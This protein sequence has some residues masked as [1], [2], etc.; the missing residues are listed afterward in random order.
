MTEQQPEEQPKRYTQEEV[1]ELMD[2]IIRQQ[3][4]PTPVRRPGLSPMAH[5]LHFLMTILTFGMWLPVWVIH[6]AIAGNRK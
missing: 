3:P 2:Q 5:V 4:E 6:A 1:N